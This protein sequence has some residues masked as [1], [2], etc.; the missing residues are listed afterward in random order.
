MTLS[1]AP[2]WPITQRYLATVTNTPF[3]LSETRQLAAWRLA[4]Q[5]W[6][7]IREAVITDN[8]LQLGAASSRR[9]VYTG[10]VSRLRGAPEA[11]LVLLAGHDHGHDTA[12]LANFYVCLRHYRLLRELMQHCICAN[13]RRYIWRLTR[14]EARQFFERQREQQPTLAGWSPQT[15][16]RVQSNTLRLVFDAGLLALPP[17]SALATGMGSGPWE[18]CRPLVTPALRRLLLADGPPPSP[19]L[20]YFLE[21]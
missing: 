11:L 5:S 19:W 16:E 7:E 13:A 10:V 2:D 21:V 6:E 14:F 12:R 8:A 18:I 9:N 20:P 3:L 4:G 15:Y 17:D 1:D